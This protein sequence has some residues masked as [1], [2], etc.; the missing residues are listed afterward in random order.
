MLEILKIATNTYH[1]KDPFSSDEV[2]LR[3]GRYSHW[4]KKGILVFAIT[5]ILTLGIAL[6]FFI[7]TAYFKH[8]KIESI[9]NQNIPHKPESPGNQPASSSG[10]T[11]TAPIPQISA[12]IA[13]TIAN[14][15]PIIDKFT[16]IH[17]IEEQRKAHENA[18]VFL[19]ENLAK[20]GAT[21]DFIAPTILKD[22]PELADVVIKDLDHKI[23][24][25]QSTEGV[26]KSIPKDG[27]KS[28]DYIVV[29]G[30]AS[31][32]NGCEAPGRR[33]VPPGEAVMVYN[34]DPTQGP[35]AQLAFPPEQVELIN[36][37]G[38]LGYNALCHLLDE[39][40][41]GEIAHGYF[42]PSKE[43]GKTIIQQL[44]ERSN[45]IEYPCVANKPSG[46]DKEVYQFLVAA[47]AFGTYANGQSVQGKERDEIEFLC[48]L[49]SY[50]AQFEKCIR[51]GQD[52]GKGVLF[53]PTAVGL[54]AFANKPINVAK[55]FY[56]AATE[57]QLSLKQNNVRVLL[58]V[59]GV[60][61]N[62][63]NQMAKL[64]KL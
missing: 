43:K 51:L 49:H 23:F 57:C 42:T 39:D 10:A 24:G 6:A 56:Q 34:G 12:S 2:E 26:E 3:N 18:K 37:G 38:N 61:E 28:R 46:C 13:E 55:A 21:I 58:Q 60:G 11:F 31:Q 9:P 17:S 30:V 47:P 16:Q 22:A 50:R 44:K 15:L 35:K 27:Q 5:T 48:A 33:T 32:F 20:I 25:S 4:Q 59:R 41:K 7:G 29:Y 62:P 63:S 36:C 8:K 45:L 64:L 1:M 52:T 53:K 14:V 54:G 40:T 19:K